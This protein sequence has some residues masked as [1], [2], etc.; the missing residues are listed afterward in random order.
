MKWSRLRIDPARSGG[1]S[2]TTS[3]AAVARLGGSAIDPDDLHA[4][5]G[6]SFLVTAGTPDVAA[7]GGE[8]AARDWNLVHAARTFGIELRPLHPPAAAVGLRDAAEF[9]QHFL[10]S[11]APLIRQALDHGQAVLAWQGWPEPC[12]WDWGIVTSAANG[13]MGFAGRTPAAEPGIVALTG[14]VIQA[15]V[16]EVVVPDTR[17]AGDVLLRAALAA[18][19]RV[20]S[21]GL[22]ADF[23]VVSGS[24]AY[25]AWGQW[26]ATGGGSESRLSAAVGDVLASRRSAARFVM[27]HER[28]NTADAATVLNAVG[29]RLQKVT[30]TA[31]AVCESFAGAA[32]DPRRALE[33]LTSLQLDECLLGD[34][35]RV[36]VTTMTA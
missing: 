6:L 4:A 29:H 14:P 26:P 19:D 36:A 24:A 2:L 23:G 12:A 1:E 8:W 31:S 7:A 3:L 5:L 28:A 17:P 21:N 27:R 9:E 16:I 25:D 33:L 13:G 10:D 22:P 35:V 15:Y 11:Y 34:V 30:D 18:G 20:L 32:R